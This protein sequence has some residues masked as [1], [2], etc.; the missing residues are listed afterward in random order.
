MWTRVCLRVCFCVNEW[1]SEW[2]SE[3]VRACVRAWVGGWVGGYVG[4]RASGFQVLI[5]GF[6]LFELCSV[7]SWQHRMVLILAESERL[8]TKE[9]QQ[10]IVRSKFGNSR[11][12][13]GGKDSKTSIGLLAYWAW[14]ELRVQLHRPPSPH[15]NP[16]RFADGRVEPRQAPSRLLIA[17]K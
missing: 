15:L 13:S 10:R 16:Q 12:I 7:N 8:L 11:C 17:L 5:D 1:V 6:L 4:E 3:C 9:E 14:D 2:V